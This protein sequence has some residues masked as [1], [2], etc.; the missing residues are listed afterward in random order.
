LVIRAVD[1]PLLSHAAALAEQGYITGASQRNWESYREEV[2]LPIGF[3]ERMRHIF[4][5]PQTSGGLLISAAEPSADKLLRSI[6][7]A[8]YPLA[9]SIG[10]VEEGPAAVEI[11]G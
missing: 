11:E 2:T 1:V 8:G 9:R 3:S 5:D 6:R 7:A 10:R 4:T